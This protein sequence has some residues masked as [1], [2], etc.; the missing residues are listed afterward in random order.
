MTPGRLPG[1][2][3]IKELLTIKQTIIHHVLNGWLY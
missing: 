3:C 1:E 2:N